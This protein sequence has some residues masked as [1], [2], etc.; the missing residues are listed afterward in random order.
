MSVQQIILDQIRAIDKWALG[1]WGA[2]ELKA[3]GTTLAF[4]VNGTK[5][6][7][8]WITVEYNEVPDTYTVEAVQ[9]WKAERKVKKS[10]EGVYCDMLVSVIDEIVG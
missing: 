3:Y 8:G 5:L 2:R 6:K 4:R 9:I 7:Q 10:V 1:A